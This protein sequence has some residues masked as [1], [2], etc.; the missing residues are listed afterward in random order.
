MLLEARMDAP[1][2]LA[3]LAVE[4]KRVQIAQEADQWRLCCSKSSGSLV[5]FAAQMTVCAAVLGF[6]F[7]SIAQDPRADNSIYISLI[8]GIVGYALAAARRRSS[9]IDALIAAAHFSRCSI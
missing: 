2:P 5:R 9:P 6:S 3:A 8:S 7:Y 4:E 1:D